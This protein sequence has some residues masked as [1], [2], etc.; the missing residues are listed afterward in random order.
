MAVEKQSWKK[1]QFIVLILSCFILENVTF[2]FES[3]GFLCGASPLSSIMVV[4]LWFVGFIQR[5]KLSS[6]V[7]PNS[8]TTKSHTVKLCRFRN[9]GPWKI[10]TVDY[11][12]FKSILDWSPL[13]IQSDN[14]ECWTQF[15]NLSLSLPCRLNFSH[16]WG[17]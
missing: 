15:R 7:Q 6:W 12:L 2:R 16:I 4:V 8:S 14:P 3:M 5:W 10:A 11:Q 1:D 17:P 13:T 9:Y